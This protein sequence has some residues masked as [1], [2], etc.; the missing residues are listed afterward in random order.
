MD[1]RQEKG[2]VLATDKRIKRIEGATWF[3]PSQTGGTAGYV[4]NMLSRMGTVL[5]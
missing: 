5:I 3:V 4:V 1:A 2:R